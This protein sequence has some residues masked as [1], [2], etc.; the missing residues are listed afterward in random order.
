MNKTAT[1]NSNKP[2]FSCPHCNSTSLTRSGFDRGIQR[3][4]CKNCLKTFKA[5]IGTPSHGLHKKEKIA[6][7]LKAARE[8]MSVRKAAQYASISN[9]TSFAWKHRFSQQLEHELEMEKI[10]DEQQCNYELKIEDALREKEKALQREAEE[11]K[12]KEEALNRLIVTARIMKQTG[13]AV[14]DIARATG[15]STDEID[16]L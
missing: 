9:N 5:T 10:F 8:G 3:Y 13:V 2:D 4:L 14:E 6:R 1:Q 16:N 11:R 7:Y 15:L 12:Q